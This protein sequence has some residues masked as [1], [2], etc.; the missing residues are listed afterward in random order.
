MLLASSEVDLSVDILSALP[1]WAN[2]LVRIIFAA[3][4]GFVIGMERKARS[5]EAGIRTHTIVCMASAIMMV[6]SKYAFWDVAA[7]VDSR[8]DGS[9]VASQVVSGIGFLGAGMI[10][11]SR[12]AL[13]GLTTA[14][15]IWATAAVGM[16]VGAGGNTMLIV[17][18]VATVL[19]VAI[20][21]FLHMPIKLFASKNHHSI[22]VQFKAQDGAVDTIKKIFSVQSVY[23]MKMSIKD[24]QWCGTLMLRTD[25]YLSDDEWLRIL[26]EN[27]FITALEY[28]EE[29]W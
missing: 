6:I 1:F 18:S 11:Y 19:I 20:H 3:L 9:R 13:H 25:K 5:K 2:L 17:G 21:V 15:G 7:A 14:A 12:G 27:P 24:G 28:A 26:E 16:V 23:R 10:V 4:C 8:F 22:L 29:E